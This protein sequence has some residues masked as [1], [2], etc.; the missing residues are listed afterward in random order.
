MYISGNELLLVRLI[1]VF[2]VSLILIESHSRFQIARKSNQIH[3]NLPSMQ[4]SAG[5]VSQEKRLMNSHMCDANQEP[6]LNFCST[7]GNLSGGASSIIG[8]QFDAQ[9]HHL[10]HGNHHHGDSKNTLGALSRANYRGRLYNTQQ[11]NGHSDD[12][13]KDSI[14]NSDTTKDLNIMNRMDLQRNKKLSWQHEDFQ[15][16]YV[17]EIFSVSIF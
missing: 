1:A 7:G 8:S 5:L 16:R 6:Q 11:A 17:F 4:S 14:A 9:N 15:V 3:S 2:K 10:H 12:I 13:E